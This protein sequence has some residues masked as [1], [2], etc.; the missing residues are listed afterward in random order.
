MSRAKAKKSYSILVNHTTYEDFPTP[1]E[2]LPLST[3]LIH[4]FL[5]ALADLGVCTKEKTMETL[6][7]NSIEDIDALCRKCHMPL[8]G[9][10]AEEQRRLK[11]FTNWQKVIL[12]DDPRTYVIS[13]RNVLKDVKDRDNFYKYDSIKQ[14][15]RRTLLRLQKKAKASEPKS[16][17]DD[18]PIDY[19][20]VNHIYKNCQLVPI[21]DWQQARTNP[22]YLHTLFVDCF[23]HVTYQMFKEYL[24]G[25]SV[26]TTR[27]IFEFCSRHGIVRF[28]RQF[29]RKFLEEHLAFIKWAGGDTQAFLVNQRAKIW[30][31]K[32][33]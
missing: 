5:D 33:L 10:V 23:P 9:S 11:E 27:S 29:G 24:F 16:T 15:V 6:S 20:E 25:D 1:D 2:L 13:M 21:T 30:S 14:G 31:S 19:V 7:A 26:A 28:N 18:I 3:N 8:N 17:E 22:R 12:H 4:S 32:T